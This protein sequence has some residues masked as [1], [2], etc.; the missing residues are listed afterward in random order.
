[1]EEKKEPT[2]KTCVVCKGRGI[3]YDEVC[4][5]CEGTGIMKE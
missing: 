2:E 1:M 3:Y 4:M 5:L